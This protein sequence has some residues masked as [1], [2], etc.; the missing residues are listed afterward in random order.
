MWI[1]LFIFLSELKKCKLCRHPVSWHG[2]EGNTRCH[3]RDVYSRRCSCQM[4]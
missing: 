3:A 4:G 1:K 2:E